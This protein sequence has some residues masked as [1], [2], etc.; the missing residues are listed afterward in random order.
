M[1][2]V[3]K[4]YAYK[5]RTRAGD[6]VTGTIIAENEAAVALHI[7]EKGHFVT[8]IRLQKGSSNL[9]AL[10]ASMRMVKIKD[11]AIFCRQFSTMINAG[12]SLIPCLSTLMEQTENIKL[13]SVLQG[14]YKNIKEGQS[15]HSSLGTYPDVF[16]S[17]MVNMIKAGEVGGSLDEVLSRLAVHFEKEHKLNERVKSAMI[18]PAVV[19]GMA[20]IVIVFI[21]LF[22]LPTF[23]KLF[24]NMKI[25]LP[26][27]TRILL[28]SSNFVL[29]HGWLLF[30]GVVLIGLA[31][32]QVL[33]LEKYKMVYDKIVLRLP[34]IGAL[35][36][37]VAIARFCRTLSTLIRG[38]VPILLALD[39]V[40]KVI[41]NLSMMNA[42]D[43]AQASVK[44]GQGIAITL[45]SS[46]VFAPLVIQ[47][48]AI[49]EESGTLEA[50]LGRIADFYESEVDDMVSRLSSLM[51][52]IIVVVLGAVIGFIV[53][54]VI[55]P[56]FDAITTIG[57]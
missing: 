2:K 38:G 19:S 42:I 25:Q 22:V 57:Y 43:K 49:G 6:L 37:K 26:L 23:V 40:K 20:V 31:V 24:A 47:M 8:D 32:V 11:L 45:A 17:I 52:P 5:A 15:L 18:Y 12:L 29:M 4:A 10:F 39:V 1:I 56:M 50:M 21:L 27:P 51:E 3:V 34:V 54:T 14:V 41:G 33:K 48:I 28:S 13:K 55:L 9:S 16:P 30:L 44:E 36:Q 46:K 53:L 35:S 7:R